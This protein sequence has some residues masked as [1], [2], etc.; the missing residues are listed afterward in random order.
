[1]DQFF[2]EGG[3]E[4]HFSLSSTGTRNVTMPLQQETRVQGMLLDRQGREIVF[5]GKV[6][7]KRSVK[8]GGSECSVTCDVIF[9]AWTEILGGAKC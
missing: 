6:S 9:T 2:P 7:V 4:G 8:A 3:S 1:M 5:R